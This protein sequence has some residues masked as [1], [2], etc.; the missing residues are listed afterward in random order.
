[1]GE[2]AFEALV[3]PPPVTIAGMRAAMHYFLEF[4]TDRLPGSTETFLT[5]LLDPPLL[6]IGRG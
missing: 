5:A 2:D 1:V 6:A 4:E 3:T